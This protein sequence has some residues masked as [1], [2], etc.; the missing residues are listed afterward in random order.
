MLKHNPENVRVK[1]K[2]LIFLK[3]AKQQNEASIDAAAKALSRFE[4]YN[5]YCDWKKFHHQQA[6]GFKAYLAKQVNKQTKKNLSK[7]TLNST[8]RYL[9]TFFQWLALQ[10]GYKS[11]I[12][13]SDAEYFNLSEKDTRIATAKRQKPVPTIE[14]IKHVIESMP[15][16]SDI[17]QRNRALVA[18]TLLTGARDSAIASLR[19][20]H[21]DL[22]AGSV[23]QDAREVDTK[24]SKTFTTYFFPV[25]DEI[26]LIV[27]DWV[28]FLKDKLLCGNDDPLFP[29]TEVGLSDER[30]FMPLGLKNEH[31]STAAPIR[32]IFK[33]SFEAAGL[34][35]F[36][37]HSFRN[38]LAGLG[39][40]LCQT[41]EDFK[42]W[43]QNLGHDKVLTTFYSYGEVQSQRQA[44]IIRELKSPRGKVGIDEDRIV[45]SLFRRMNAK[46]AS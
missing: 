44:D 2:Y 42:A 17:D 3:E 38:T 37:P 1:R 26:R 36:N 13:Y 45:E 34:S 14:Q 28:V 4:E 21:V 30:R 18:F 20:K 8:L 23:F 33:E 10:S 27:V 15:V 39:E 11:R 16:H 31:W 12:N 9:K 7:A 32:R 25:G 46:N 29:K 41:P 5:K 22:I 43:S 19:I 40:K 6:V 24:F 35:Y